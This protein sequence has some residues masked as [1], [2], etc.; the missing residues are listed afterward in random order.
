VSRP[1]RDRPCYVCPFLQHY[2]AYRETVITRRTTFELAKAEARIHILEGLTTA[3]DH[4]DAVIETIRRSQNR[5][6]ASSNLQKAFALSKEQAKAILDM[7]LGRLAALERKRIVDE[8]AEV[9]RVPEG[10]QILRDRCCGCWF[11]LGAR[12]PTYRFSHPVRD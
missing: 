2:I 1:R 9:R 11:H 3:L 10:L 6:T 12:R 4:L 8:L 7:Q 5:D